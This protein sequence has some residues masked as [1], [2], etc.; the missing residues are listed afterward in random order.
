MLKSIRDSLEPQHCLQYIPYP[1]QIVADHDDS[2]IQYITCL[3]FRVCVELSNK[4]GAGHEQGVIDNS[5]V[6]IAILNIV[7]VI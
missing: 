3:H 5:C 7:K 1:L 6:I 2:I 4:K